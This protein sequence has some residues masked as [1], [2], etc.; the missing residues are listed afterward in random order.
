MPRAFASTFVPVPQARGLTL[1]LLDAVAPLRGV[2][3]RQMMNG[4]R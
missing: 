1:A 2:F 3:A 4:R